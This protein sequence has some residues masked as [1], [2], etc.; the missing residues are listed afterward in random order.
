MKSVIALCL[1]LVCCRARRCHREYGSTDEAAPDAKRI[2]A[3]EDEADLPVFPW[4]TLPAETF[5]SIFPYVV[6]TR[7]KDSKKLFQE[8]GMLCMKNMLG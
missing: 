2:R 4:T 3:D 6:K 1:C 7:P 5:V 8:A